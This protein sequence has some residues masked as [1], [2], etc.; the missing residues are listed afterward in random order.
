MLE[1]WLVTG[2]R[3][4]TE[5]STWIDGCVWGGAKV[6]G[7][8]YIWFLTGQCV[9]VWRE[10]LMRC[11]LVPYQWWSCAQDEESTLESCDSEGFLPVSSGL[12]M[13]GSGGAWPQKYIGN[14]QI[15]LE[16][17]VSVLQCPQIKFPW[18]L[19]EAHWKLI[20]ISLFSRSQSW[21]EITKV[22][23]ISSLLFECSKI[24][25]DGVSDRKA[26]KLWLWRTVNPGETRLAFVQPVHALGW[27]ER[28]MIHN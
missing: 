18:K 5:M 8:C 2:W 25:C 11:V 15:S 9:Q 23:W 12:W 21:G 10:S 3:T 7:N 27:D 14:A 13:P 20:F 16:V 19:S 4:V 26:F 17:N 24:P 6:H 1:A 22:G 28:S